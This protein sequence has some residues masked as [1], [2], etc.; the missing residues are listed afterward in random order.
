MTGILVVAIALAGCRPETQPPADAGQ[1]LAAGLPVSAASAAEQDSSPMVVRRLWYSQDNL[2]FWGG[3]SPDG[4]YMTYVDWWTG[5]L[6]LHDF[7]T[8]EDRHLTDE[9]SLD[10]SE[11]AVLSAVSPDGERVAYSWE[12]GQYDELRVLRIDGSGHRVLYSNEA[13]NIHP[14]E[15]SA[16]GSQILVGID[17]FADRT[18]QIGL[19][20]VAEGS[21]RVL[22]SLDRRGAF[23]E[24]LSP[25]GR[26]VIYDFPT[27]VGFSERDIYL[28]DTT[29]S[30]EEVL[31]EHPANDLV[32]G[33]APDGEHVLF[34]SDRGGTLGGW[35]LPM[36]NGK[37][38]GEA[39]LVKPEL[40]RINP[41]G[42]ARNGSYFYGVRMAMFDVYLAAIDPE[43][44]Q[45][46]GQPTRVS[47]N[48]FG[49]NGSPE[50]SPDGRYLAYISERSP[51][52]T[53]GYD[54]LVIHS[55]ENG[56]V[57]ELRPKLGSLTW[58][59]WAPDGGSILVRS[60]DQENRSGLFSI[61][62]QT[63]DVRPLIYFGDDE[64]HLNAEWRADGK[65]LVVRTFASDGTRLG[66][67][68]LETG[69][70]Q[71]IYRVSHP[72]KLI[73]RDFAVSP[74][75]LQLAFALRGDGDVGLMVIPVTGGEPRRLVRFTTGEPEPFFIYWS[76][77][78]QY[79][80][81]VRLGG[82]EGEEKK[83]LW[84][85]PA[86]GGMPEQL[87]WLMEVSALAMRF[88]PDGRRVAL[89]RVEGTG[90]EVWVL[91]DFL[92]ATAGAFEEK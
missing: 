77:D 56:E 8:G 46:L 34:A 66:I 17:S 55:T 11:F 12:N 51:R 91:E 60:S 52:G 42:F 4:R 15:W 86:G 39:R 40:W 24:S 85:I 23:E 61:D 10:E 70:E 28:I 72:E 14:V 7:T 65:A 37:A 5:D 38:A 18:K 50:W 67:R 49:S 62:V 69:N 27:D 53:P 9:A 57:R 80:Y 87:H 36:A 68:D 16:D 47:Q 84:R 32:L 30:D 63:G 19:V 58:Q 22:K 29:T 2:E 78:G 3:P 31:V 64:Y 45:L 73:K 79:L 1:L 92:P 54:A 43:T 82:S 71:V 33:W 74:D 41:L 35:L 6:A 26:Y 21:L 90:S 13:M 44:G 25:D 81:Y 75:G 48:Y 76:L 20:S 59:R 89:T 83:G 88:H